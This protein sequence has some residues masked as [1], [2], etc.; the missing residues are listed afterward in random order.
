MGVSQALSS[1]ATGASR[2]IGP[3]ERTIIPG[4]K[5]CICTINPAVEARNLRLSIFMRS[6]LSESDFRTKCKRW[7]LHVLADVV[8]GE[9]NA[10]LEGGVA[11]ED[12]LHNPIRRLIS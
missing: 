4:L 6:N 8:G 11:V 10:I 9:F 2:S 12:K 5:P 7:G 3:S 1:M